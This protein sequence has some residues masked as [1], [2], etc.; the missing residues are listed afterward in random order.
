ML[1]TALLLTMTAAGQTQQITVDVNGYQ[2][3]A[4]VDRVAR[5]LT[6][7]NGQN[8][9]I[10]HYAVASGLSDFVIPG[11]YDGYGDYNVIIAPF[12]FRFCSNLVRIKVGEGV[13]TIGDFA[14]VGCGQTTAIDLPSTLKTVGCGAF[15]GLSLLKVIICRSA[16]PPAW[17]Y[18]DVFS[19]D[20][21]AKSTAVG[22]DKRA[23]PLKVSPAHTA[24]INIMMWWA[25]AMPL[26][27][28][29]KVRAEW[30]K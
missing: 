16:T 5:T 7:G 8:A 18:G 22:A 12:A 27:L 19:Y 21:T 25:G 15:V 6:L 3:T 14:F 9:C 4:F 23:P 11:K 29:M 26:A 28:S 17:A 13:T 24:P 30:W 20:G 1:L 10:P 2:A